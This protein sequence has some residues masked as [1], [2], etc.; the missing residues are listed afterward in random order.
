MSP[1]Q[2]FKQK[3][4]QQLEMQRI[5]DHL[6]Q[7][8]TW[9]IQGQQIQ[10]MQ[11]LKSRHAARLVQEQQEENAWI[12]AQAQRQL[13]P[14]QAGQAAP[15]SPQMMAPA[16]KKSH[17]QKRREARVEAELKKRNPY[18]D[19]T[20]Y[21]LRES[22]VRDLALR[23]N[24]FTGELKRE[25]EE[26]RIDFRL[27]RGFLHGC[28]MKKGEPLNQ[29]EAEHLR[30][31]REY[32]ADY[33]SCDLQRRQPHLR[34]MVD[35]VLQVRLTPE[36]LTK[37]YVESHI[38]EIKSIGDKLTCMSNVKRDPINQ[39]FFNQLP[40]LEKDLL[41]AQD[42]LYAE[43]GTLCV[44]VFQYNGVDPSNWDYMSS[45]QTVAI[46]NIGPQFLN[47]EGSQSALESRDK[48]VD[49]AFKGEVERH[50]QQAAQSKQAQIAQ[51]RQQDPE[52]TMGL[53]GYAPA[54]ATAMLRKC[55]DKIQQNSHAYMGNRTTVDGL[56]QQI[57]QAVD[58]WT[59]LQLQADN[60]RA[61]SARLTDAR[62]LQQEVYR[63]TLQ[64]YHKAA[65]KVNLAWQRIEG[66]EQKLSRLLGQ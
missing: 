20:S 31:D 3:Q 32:I 2:L 66:M 15:G 52:S 44:A 56:Y 49:A 19:Y 46:R 50:I 27:L 63:R 11:Q 47:I 34:R 8:Q 13:P 30:Q 62:G 61:A 22:V 42:E 51:Q 45:D 64:E 57:F 43:L 55:R 24:S 29:Q 58:A 9:D 17:K 4:L 1:D 65:E 38:V 35:A 5:E 14:A 53:T 28:R 21:M 26:N 60:C 10:D 40:Q 6:T 39:P 59:G 54:Q 48:K 16:V 23:D 41:A 18:C 7:I 36:M 12:Q 33:A 37:E 25:C